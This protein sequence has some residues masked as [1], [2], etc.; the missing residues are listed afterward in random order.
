MIL[1]HI[2]ISKIFYKFFKVLFLAVFLF[3]AGPADRP[4]DRSLCPGHARLCM[5]VG[6]PI[7]QPTESSLLSGF[8]SRSTAFRKLC[9]LLEAGRPV[10]RPKPNGY[11]PAGRTVDRTG[12]PP[13]LQ[14]P[15]GSFLFGPILK[16][17]FRTVFLADFFWVLWTFFRSNKLKTNKF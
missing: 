7:G 2:S 9:F 1:S 17:V 13:S 5:S 14:S 4:V 11:M 16:S 6:R 10:G 3:Q 12:R 15:N 8:L